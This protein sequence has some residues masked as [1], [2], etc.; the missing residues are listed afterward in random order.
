M[1]PARERQWAATNA[2]AHQLD[3]ELSAPLSDILREAIAALERCPFA[4]RIDRAI[5]KS[6]SSNHR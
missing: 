5:A 3:T 2:A 6:K 4:E 1:V